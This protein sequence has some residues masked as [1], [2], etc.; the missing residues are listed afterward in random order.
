M[1]NFLSG[2]YA[3][4]ILDGSASAAA[5]YLKSDVRHMNGEAASSATGGRA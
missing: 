4:L 1:G 3:R 5:S 2:A